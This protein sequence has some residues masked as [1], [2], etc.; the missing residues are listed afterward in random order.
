MPNLI[1]NFV[2]FNE[3]GPMMQMLHIAAFIVLSITF[4]D[5]SIKIRN[6]KSSFKTYGLFV[7]VWSATLGLAALCAALAFNLVFFEYLMH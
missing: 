5:L 7:I 4:F 1:F 2:R 3:L 6:K